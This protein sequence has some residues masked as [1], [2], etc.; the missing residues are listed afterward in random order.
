M[1]VNKKNS[2][3]GL[4]ILEEENNMFRRIIFFICLYVVFIVTAC[5]SSKSVSYYVDHP[6]EIKTKLEECE[7]DTANFVQDGDC[8]NASRAKGKRFF[9]PVK[10]NKKNSSPGLFILEEENN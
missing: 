10:V 4:F 8:A 1:K 9:A 6:E 2:S 5:D 3:P 7:G